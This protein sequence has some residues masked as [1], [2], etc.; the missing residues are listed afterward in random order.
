MRIGILN[1]RPVDADVLR[2]ALA[3][4]RDSEVVWVAPTIDAAMALC[5]VGAPDLILVDVAGTVDGVAATRQIRAVA[6]SA[7]LIVT[8]SVEAHAD[9]VFEAMGEGAID[10]VDAPPANEEWPAAAS[11][12]LSKMDTVAHLIK[13]PVSLAETPAMPRTL[14]ALGASAGGPATL[15]ELLHDLPNPFPA[16]LVVV[17]HVEPQFVHGMA[18]WLCRH[19]SLPVGL[20]RDGDRP[21]VGTVLIA[22][23]GEHLVLKGPERLGYTPDPADLAYRPSIDVFFTSVA[24]HWKGDAIGVLLT[25][26]GTDG[27]AGLKAMRNRG[28]HT[29]AQDQTTSL[30]YGMPKAAAR[31]DAA[32]D[33]LPLQRIAPRLVEKVVGEVV[34]VRRR[35]LTPGSDPRS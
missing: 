34:G 5:D 32:V 18:A 3:L 16:A 7:V 29:I 10:A 26:M 28:F 2:R 35:G 4:R 1:D 11:A 23:T 14:V 8:S 22:G 30:V 19:T 15:A 20:A 17:Q 25:G 31:M 6:A 24:R 21:A 9:R 33:I 12:F 13:A 27:A